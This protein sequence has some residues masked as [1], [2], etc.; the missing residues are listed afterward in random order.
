MISLQFGCSRAV[1]QGSID[2]GA[3]DLSYSSMQIMSGIPVQV[4][5]HAEECGWAE[6]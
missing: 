4:Q 5:F 3:M 1:G 2:G 6:S